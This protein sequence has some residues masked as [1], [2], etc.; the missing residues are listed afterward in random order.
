MTAFSDHC[1][2]LKLRGLIWCRKSPQRFYKLC[3]WVWGPLEAIHVRIEETR[4]C[5][6]AFK[7]AQFWC[8]PICHDGTGKVEW[9][10]CL[11]KSTQA[12]YFYWQSCTIEF[13]L[14]TYTLKDIQK[15]TSILCTSSRRIS[16]YWNVNKC[17]WLLMLANRTIS[18]HLCLWQFTRRLYN[19]D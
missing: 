9:T 7:L 6:W 14:D 4:S 11:N 8:Q 12:Y 2:C 3:K 16:F 15:Y 10:L 5:F 17:I 19:A 13:R 18:S 1:K